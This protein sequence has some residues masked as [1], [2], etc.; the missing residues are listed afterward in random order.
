[1]GFYLDMVRSTKNN[2][3]ENYPREILQLFSIGLYMLNQDGTLQ[4]DDQGNP[5]PTYSQESINNFS[6]VLT[7][8]TYCNITC[9]NSAPGILNYKDPMIL[10]PIN[11]DTT[12]KTLLN[13]PDPV[14]PS[15]PACGNCTT[16][17]ATTAYANDSLNRALDNIFHHPNVAPET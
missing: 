17:E 15:V 6:K 10:N 9:S 11:H 8:W 2:P 14:N 7:G 13:Y 1:M 4:L 12:G 16:P 5:I 3:N